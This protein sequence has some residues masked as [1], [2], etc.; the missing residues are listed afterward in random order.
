ML[1]FRINDVIAIIFPNVI[2][3]NRNNIIIQVFGL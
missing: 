3:N 2:N 1:G